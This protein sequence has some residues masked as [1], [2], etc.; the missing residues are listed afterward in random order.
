MITLYILACLTFCIKGIEIKNLTQGVLFDNIAN[1]TATNAKWTVTLRFDLQ[2]IQNSHEK[3][4]KEVEKIQ[5]NIVA[6]ENATNCTDYAEIRSNIQEEMEVLKENLASF[7]NIIPAEPSR[8]KRALEFMGDAI[9]FFFGNL[10]AEDGRT[11]HSDI[12]KIQLKNEQ[13]YHDEE[14]RLTL[15]KEVEKSLGNNFIQTAA[16]LNRL[17]VDLSTVINSNAK[18]ASK[19]LESLKKKSHLTNR[20][21]L[22]CFQLSQ[23]HTNLNDLTHG[24]M[25]SMHGTLSPFLIP[26][27]SFL[28]ILNQINSTLKLNSKMLWPVSVSNLAKYYKIASVAAMQQNNHL[29]LNISIPIITGYS[30]IEINKIIGYPIYWPNIQNYIEW[31]LKPY[32][33]INRHAQTFYLPTEI[34]ISGCLGNAWHVCPLNIAWRTHS[35]ST[36]ETNLYFRNS[37][38]LCMRKINKNAEDM[39]IKTTTGWVLTVPKQGVIAVACKNQELKH[40]RIR[41]TVLISEAD[42][43]TIMT[44]SV[45]IYPEE[46]TKI[47]LAGNLRTVKIPEITDIIPSHEQFRTLNF[48]AKPELASHLNQLLTKEKSVPLEEFMAEINSFENSPIMGTNTLIQGGLSISSVI[49]ISAIGYLAYHLF[50]QRQHTIIRVE[51]P[52]CST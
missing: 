13:F 29:M 8:M 28:R 30:D 14:R 46:H 37:S 11:L 1:I 4:A 44:E 2:K 52:G 40:I 10:N 38:D 12:N 43:C 5:A 49:T 15:I 32:I 48:T 45:K 17:N 50:T 7:I 20:L 21:Q 39:A 51:N 47:K 19:E 34:E 27:T 31:N 22:L 16:E 42:E 18:L 25:D 23:I 36:C 3:L 26:S 33:A 9:K 24:I 6:V 35:I 41:G